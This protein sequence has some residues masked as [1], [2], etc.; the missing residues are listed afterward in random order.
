MRPK[1]IK[2]SSNLLSSIE[3]RG[4]NCERDWSWPVTWAP[5]VRGQSSHTLTSG[6]L[7]YQPSADIKRCVCLG[8][9]FTY[10]VCLRRPGVCSVSSPLILLFRGKNAPPPT[11]TPPRPLNA[12]LLASVCPW[13]TGCPVLLPHLLTA[14]L[15]P[16][17]LGPSAQGLHFGSLSLILVDSISVWKFGPLHLLVARKKWQIRWRRVCAPRTTATNRWKTSLG[18]S[19]S[20]DL[21]GD[22]SMCVCLCVWEMHNNS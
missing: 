5:P 4:W 11:T 3:P 16:L 2:V 7:H 20:V 8:S 1:S 19:S 13:M 6:Q 9:C 10:G 15:R 17:Y 22:T 18:R 14:P 21:V 12:H